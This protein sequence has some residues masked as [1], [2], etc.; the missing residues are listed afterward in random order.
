MKTLQALVLRMIS[1]RQSL[2]NT[3]VASPHFVMHVSPPAADEELVKE[4]AKADKI[5]RRTLVTTSQEGI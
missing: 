5:L 3:T 4:Q 2:V 1:E